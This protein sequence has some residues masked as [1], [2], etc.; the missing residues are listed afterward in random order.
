MPYVPKLVLQAEL[1]G[2]LP[3]VVALVEVRSDPTE[4]HQWVV[5]QRLRE[6]NVVEVVA[7]VDACAQGLVVLF[8]DVQRVQTIIA[9][10]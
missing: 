2:V 6:R 1:D 4:R 10:R 9:I 3:A 5:L 8:L 7:S